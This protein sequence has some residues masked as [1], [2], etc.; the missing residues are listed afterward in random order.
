MARPDEIKASEIA[1]FKAQGRDEH[2][3]YLDP[4]WRAEQQKLMGGRTPADLEKASND[5]NWATAV[6]LG[7]NL[8]PGGGAIQ[9]TNPFADNF[10]D[11]T[12]VANR[13]VILNNLGDIDPAMRQRWAASYAKTG[14]TSGFADELQAER[15]RQWGLAFDRDVTNPSVVDR[16]RRGQVSTVG[17]LGQA[18]QAWAQRQPP[19]GSRPA[20]GLGSVTPAAQGPAAMPAAMPIASTGTS[21]MRQGFSSVRRAGIG[22]GFGQARQARG[23]Y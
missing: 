17:P 7:E 8:T 5:W 21:G 23:A 20:T 16:W 14:N 4:Y 10:R 3:W 9:S 11:M 18:Q 6:G 2:G 12:G 15:N 1:A 19:A 13:D 22:G